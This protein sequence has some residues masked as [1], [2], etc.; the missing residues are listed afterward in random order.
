MAGDTILVVDE[1]LLSAVYSV[2][3][4]PFFIGGVAIVAAAGVL[5][6]LSV[7][8]RREKFTQRFFDLAFDRQRKEKALATLEEPEIKKP[9]LEEN[10]HSKEDELK[11]KEEGLKTRKREELSERERLLRK[12]DLEEKVKRERKLREREISLMRQAHGE[13]VSYHEWVR[14]S[15]MGFDYYRGYGRP[16][17][18]APPAGGDDF[19]V[20]EKQRIRSLIDAAVG[21]FHRGEV[22]EAAFSKMVLDYQ[23]QLIDVEVQLRESF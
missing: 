6:F 20:G 14:P 23:R 7:Y 19:L 2:V 12:R 5:W 4:S 17:M 3:R 21:R 9:S 10:L 16:V 22:D 13:R 1:Q 18:Y 8:E 11:K 15:G